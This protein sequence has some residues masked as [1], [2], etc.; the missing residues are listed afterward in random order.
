MKSFL[1]F[2]AEAEKRAEEKFKKG[3]S[4]VDHTGRHYAKIVDIN[5]P[6]VH[7]DKGVFHHTKVKKY[8]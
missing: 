5:H 1:N 3:D 7:T 4:V 2:I 6:M 8:S